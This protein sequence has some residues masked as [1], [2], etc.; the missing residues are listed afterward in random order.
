MVAI[1]SWLDDDCGCSLELLSLLLERFWTLEDEDLTLLD[2]EDFGCFL[3]LLDLA[4]LLDE[5][6]VFSQSSQTDED[7]SSGS[8]VELPLSSPHAIR[9]AVAAASIRN[10]NPRFMFHRRLNWKNGEYFINASKA[11]SFKSTFIS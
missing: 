4:L 8:E 3:E 2:D 11:N 6:G 9:E 7:E 10:K 1:F 5:M